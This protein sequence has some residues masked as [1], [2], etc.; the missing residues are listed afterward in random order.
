M[1]VLTPRLP[2]VENGVSLLLA[3]ASRAHVGTVHAGYVHSSVC[4]LAGR[5]NPALASLIVKV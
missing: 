4:V 5:P 2:A 3:L 1:A